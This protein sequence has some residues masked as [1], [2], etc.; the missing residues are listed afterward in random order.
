MINKNKLKDIFLKKILIFNK[1]DIDDNEGFYP[2]LYNE[3]NL[4]KIKS[5][6]YKPFSGSNKQNQFNYYTINIYFYPIQYK[7]NIA[8]IQY[9]GHVI[10]GFDDNNGLEILKSL[11]EDS[12]IDGVFILNSGGRI[13]YPVTYNSTYRVLGQLPDEIF[14]K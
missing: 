5:P 14:E 12:K 9:N 2:M 8:W 10:M 1:F 3:I 7:D 13:I 4:N 11:N 6:N